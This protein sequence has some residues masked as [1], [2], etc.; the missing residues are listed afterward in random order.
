MNAGDE[1]PAAGTIRVPIEWELE[2][3]TYSPRDLGVILP[4]YIRECR[5][6][7][8]LEVRIVHGKGT[9]ALGRAVHAIL[10]KMHGVES[11]RLAG[12]ATM[13]EWG[14]TLARLKPLKEEG[15]KDGA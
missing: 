9:G 2:L 1:K 5:E 11:F 10:G 3:H 7:G 12:S 4:E 13:G 14:A 15:Q 6:R 8:I